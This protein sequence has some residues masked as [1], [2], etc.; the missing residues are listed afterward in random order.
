MQSKNL[1]MKLMRHIRAPKGPITASVSPHYCAVLILLSCLHFCGYADTLKCTTHYESYRNGVKFASNESYT[2]VLEFEK[3]K[4]QTIKSTVNGKLVSH[5]VTQDTV[6]GQTTNYS[7]IN[8]QLIRSA[9][10]ITDEKITYALYAQQIRSVGNASE[11]PSKEIHTANLEIN[12]KTGEMSRTSS[13][14]TQKEKYLTIA[15]GHCTAY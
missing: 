15:Q 4:V 8:N 9:V 14:Q 11:Q 13:I 6:D 3:D 12:R 10:S 5:E 1:A 7:N 2:E